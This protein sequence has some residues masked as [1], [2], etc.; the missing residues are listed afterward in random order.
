MASPRDEN[1]VPTLKCSLQTD[2]TTV[3]NVLAV[4]TTHRLSVSDGTSGSSVGR[5]PAVRDQDRVPV[6]LAV[7][8]VDGL[9]P[10]EIYADS[11][12]AMLVTTV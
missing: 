7:S 3:V 12:G 8:Y 6:L 1:R 2:G 5:L 11:T 9:T 4:P 10:V